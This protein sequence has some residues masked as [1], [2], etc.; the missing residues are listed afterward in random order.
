MQ[1]KLESGGFIGGELVNIGGQLC[2]AFQTSNSL[3]GNLG[4]CSN[5]GNV[6]ALSI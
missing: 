6:L 3:E 1:K 4:G 5:E 2:V